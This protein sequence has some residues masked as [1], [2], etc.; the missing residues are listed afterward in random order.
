MLRPETMQVLDGPD[1]RSERDAQGDVVEVHYYGDM[2][3]YDVRLDGTAATVT[4]SMKNLANGTV[5]ER[6]QSVRIGWD[7]AALVPF[8]D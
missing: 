6:G 8:I 1:S 7:P 2:T 5:L 4:I 3:Y